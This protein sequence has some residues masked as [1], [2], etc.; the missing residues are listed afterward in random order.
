MRFVAYDPY[1]GSAPEGFHDVRMVSLDELLAASDF[2]TIH[3]PKTKETAGL[4][5]AEALAKVK[6]SV[7][8]KLEMRI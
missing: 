3:I 4:I 1:V 7:R 8:I 2:I 6:P 5:G